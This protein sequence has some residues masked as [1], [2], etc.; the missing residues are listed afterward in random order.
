MR[1]G[2]NAPGFL[3]LE[4]MRLTASEL[5]AEL[6]AIAG[7]V[8][9]LAPTHAS[10]PERWHNQK[11]ELRAKV[12]KLIEACGFRVQPSSPRAFTSPAAD[13]GIAAIRH[14][15]RTIPIERRSGR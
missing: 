13:S 14:N 9:R 5:E 7:Q 4:A 8:D 3:L 1:P 6:N 2:G 12:R 15:G 10:D 11:S